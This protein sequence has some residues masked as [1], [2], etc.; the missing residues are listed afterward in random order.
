MASPSKVKGLSFAAEVGLNFRL[1]KTRTG[2]GE[3]Q[4]KLK[5]PPGREETQRVISVE[6]AGGRHNK[7]KEGLAIS[8]RHTGTGRRSAAT[9]QRA[10]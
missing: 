7:D 5:S 6:A 3:V 8:Q 2:N 10:G 1:Q 4:Q 9:G